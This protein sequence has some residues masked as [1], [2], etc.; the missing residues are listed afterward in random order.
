MQNSVA[1]TGPERAR[2]VGSPHE[3]L[4]EFSHPRNAATSDGAKTDALDAR[5][6]AREVLGR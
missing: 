6:A 1:A 3:K 5:R 4:I 2:T